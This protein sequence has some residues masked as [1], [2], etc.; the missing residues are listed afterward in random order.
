M[1]A[2]VYGNRD[3]FG[4]VSSDPQGRSNRRASVPAM[5]ACVIA[6]VILMGVGYAIARAL[7]LPWF[8]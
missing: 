8:G 4:D 7:H 2:T 6:V 5:L 3:A 1:G